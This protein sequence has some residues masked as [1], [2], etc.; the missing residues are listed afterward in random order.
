[1]DTAKYK[2]NETPKKLSFRKNEE[3]K[4]KKDTFL[5]S[6]RGLQNDMFEY[7]GKTLL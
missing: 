5:G 1:M 2:K 7:T 6:K 3:V 4:D